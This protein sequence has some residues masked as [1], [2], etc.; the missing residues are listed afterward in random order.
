MGGMSCI[1]GY[2]WDECVG[3]IRWGKSWMGWQTE[4]K[5]FKYPQLKLS[6]REISNY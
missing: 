6:V 2:V 1:M 5:G 3:V 4:H